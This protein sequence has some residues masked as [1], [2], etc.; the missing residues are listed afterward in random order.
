MSRHVP[1][2]WVEGVGSASQIFSAETFNNMNLK[3]ALI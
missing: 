3:V 2:S 1:R